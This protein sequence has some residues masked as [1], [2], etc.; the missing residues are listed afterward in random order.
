MF[1]IRSHLTYANVVATMC[2]FLLIGGGVAAANV[3]V[4]SNS[5]VASKTISGHH[6]PSG[7]HANIIAGSVNGAD[8]AVGAVGSN[9]LAANSVTGAKVLNGSLSGADVGNDSLTGQQIS[10]STLAGGQI[11]G[12]DAATVG[13]KSASQLVQGRG[14]V[15][16]GSQFVAEGESKFVMSVSN[17]GDISADCNAS[18]T[19]GT[20][21][22]LNTTVKPEDFTRDNVATLSS[23]EVAP[24]TSVSRATGSSDM[25]TYYLFALTGAETATVRLGFLTPGDDPNVPTGFCLVY[26]QTLET[27]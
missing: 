12:V 24:S 17:F 16:S 1:R 11:T 4:S 5:Q 27:P 22:Y 15:S 21:T 13:G 23:G 7:D 26:A 19:G 2:L 25:Q 6:P 9:G 14:S 3:I 8:L 10:E 20:L 18:A